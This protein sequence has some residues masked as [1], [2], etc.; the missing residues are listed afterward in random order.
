MTPEQADKLIAA[1]QALQVGVG[2][3]ASW[4]LLLAVLKFLESIRGK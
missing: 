3:I 1:V 4:L 2:L